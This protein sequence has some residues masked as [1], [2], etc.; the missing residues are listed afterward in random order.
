MAGGVIDNG[1]IQ[2]GGARY[3]GW[4][5]NLGLQAATTTNANDSIKI[6][7]A[8]AALSQ[9]NYL[10]VSVPS[11]T[12]GLLS[13]LSAT[14]D[15][16]INLTGAHWGL[17]TLGDFT[18]VILHVYAIN[19][20]GTL[21][22]GISPHPGLREVLGTDDET[23][24]TNVTSSEK[25][26]VDTALSGNSPCQHVG[27]FKADFDDTGGAAEDLWAVQTAFGDIVIEPVPCLGRHELRYDDFSAI[28]S[29]NTDVPQFTTQTIAQ[30]SICVQKTNDASDGLQILVTKQGK[31]GI[32]FTAENNTSSAIHMGIGKNLSAA[33]KDDVT[34]VTSNDSMF[35]RN[36]SGGIAS[37]APFAS[38]SVT[39]WL[40]VGDEITPV[41]FGAATATFPIQFSIIYLGP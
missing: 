13:T 1:V 18:D 16:T 33:E 9:Q 6:Q 38:G 5:N 39:L 25:V 29:N 37:F 12:A 4:F 36:A 3:P 34:S 10:W 15:V 14:A 2:Q 24:A 32:H 11:T 19:D 23:T 26:L 35:G 40:D 30:G 27:W 7:G 20:S 17:G 22:W 31:Y 41:M 8:T 28:S 21:K